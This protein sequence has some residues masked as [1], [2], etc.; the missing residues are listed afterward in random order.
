[1]ATV[2]CSVPDELNEEF[3]QVFAGQNKSAIIAELMRKA[4]A[5]VKHRKQREEIFHALTQR[6]AHRPSLKGWKL[7]IARAAGRP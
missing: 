2:N 4:V 1:M 7:H 6:R 3:D 5:V